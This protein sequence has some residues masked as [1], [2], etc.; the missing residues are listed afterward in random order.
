MVYICDTTLRDGEQAAGVAFSVEEKVAI[1]R[2]LDEGGVLEIEAGTP[3]MGGMERDAVAAIAGLGLGARVL[4]WNRA[5]ISDIDASAAT[6]VRAM[7]I[8]L[9]VSDI[10][11]T[12][13]LGRDRVW[14]LERLKSVVGYAKDK[15]LYVC[16]GAE[17]AS[18]ADEGF[19]AEYGGL[20]Q[21]AGADRLRFADTVGVLDPFLTAGKIARLIS[22]VYIPVEIHTHNDFGLATANA[23]AGV[24]AGAAYVSTTVLG[25][26]ERAGNAATEEV[27]MAAKHI[28]GADTGID[29]ARLPRLC[30]Y[31]AKA[32]GRSISPDKPIVGGGIFHH[33]SGI[34]ADGVIK[35]PSAY[36]AYPPEEVGLGRDITIGKHSGRAALVHRLGGMGI[37]LSG[38]DAAGMLMEVRRICVGLK[39]ELSDAELLKL[40]E[41]RPAA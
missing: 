27:V 13:K 19:L 8:S 21:S 20:A 40:Y 4:A 28:M 11:I 16:A 26:G 33:E 35:L 10:L 6:G 14:V 38:K 5:V 2:L 1:A 37:N 36:E 39:R 17:D 12:H 7:S 3:A 29:P 25:I 22:A 24:R 15:G 32:A 30:G 31:V 41:S 23:L 18:R 9:P 34:H